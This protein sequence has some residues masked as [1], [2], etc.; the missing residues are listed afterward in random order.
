MR[1]EAGEDPKGRSTGAGCGRCGIWLVLGLLA[2]LLPGPGDGG[3]ASAAEVDAGAP[4]DAFEEFHERFASS[5]YFYPRHGARPLGW[6][7]FEVWADLSVDPGFGDEDF[8]RATL[9]GDLPGDTLAMARVGVRK[10]LPA[11]FDLGVA[12]GTVVDGDL[13]LFSVELQRALWSGG[14]LSP[15]LG[16]RLTGSHTLD[17]GAYELEQYGLEVV[18]SKGFTVVTVFGGAGV[19]HSEGTLDRQGRPGPRR[20][21]EDAT[22]EVLFAGVRIRLLL[23]RITVSVEQGEE[24]QGAVRVGFGF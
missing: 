23:P 2:V 14:A 19:V 18:A 3:T 24:L 22:R 15:A 4:R 20:F 10:G 5:V 12:W 8:A 16:F 17:S 1:L 11:K 9:D 6:T 7:G 13:D 21:E